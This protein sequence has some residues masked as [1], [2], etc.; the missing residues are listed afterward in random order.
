MVRYVLFEVHSGY[1]WGDTASLPAFSKTGQ[2]PVD[3]ARA[4]D[5]HLGD[6]ESRYEEVSGHEM[7]GRDGYM[8]YEVGDIV[9]VHYSGDDAE[10]IALVERTGRLVCGLQKIYPC[11]D[12]GDENE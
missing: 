6:Y 7:R 11:E 4:L 8:V 1:I 3:A 2:T 9:P 5:E 12:M 10:V